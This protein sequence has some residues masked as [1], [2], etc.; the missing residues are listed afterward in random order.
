MR[1]NNGLEFAQSSAESELLATVLGAAEGIGLISS[2]ADLGLRFKARLHMNAAAAFGVI[3]RRGSGRV[4][5]LYVGI[6][7]LQEQQ[8]RKSLE[9]KKVAGLENPSDLLTKHLT[10]EV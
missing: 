7:W 8:L 3:E 10:Q 1:E 2:W 4:R 6:V 5:H 9:L